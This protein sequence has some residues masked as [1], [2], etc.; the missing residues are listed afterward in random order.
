MAFSAT[1]T[2]RDRRRRLRS[3][4]WTLNTRW[5]LNY[6]DPKT[7]K[8][9][10]EFFERQ[11]DATARRNA[12]VA[13]VETRT[14]V[15]SR[16][17][18][19]IAAAVE[20]WLSDRRGEV[21]GRTLAGYEQMAR[22]ITGPLVSGTARQRREHTEAGVLPDGVHLLPLLG[23]RKVNDLTTGQI[24]HWHKTLTAEVG[25]YTANRARSY[26][27]GVLALAAEDLGVRP[28]AM[29]AKLGRG[30]T[31]EKKAILTPDQVTRVLEACRAD[32]EKGLY[33][34]FAFLTGTRPSEQLGLLWDEV[35]LD[36]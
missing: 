11:K 24:R 15:P 27:A 8:R 33:V 7:G 13:Q 20:R 17:Q 9:V 21:K 23:E 3:G 5:V 36:A 32:P 29:P 2:K 18:I 28:P 22:Y 1:V 10:Q 31:R 16:E 35:D 14:Y 4:E 12:L 25:L 26:L 34:A 19:T 30:R 6:R